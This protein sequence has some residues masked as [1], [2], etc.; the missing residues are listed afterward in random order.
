MQYLLWKEW[1]ERRLWLLLW[2]LA[3]AGTA[4]VGKGPSPFGFDVPAGWT[5]IPALFAL[6]SGLAG[7]GSE[8]VGGRAA[9]L[10]SR[11]V[12]WGRVLLAK[13]LPG[14]ATALLGAIVG[15]VAC[16]FTL[17]AH[18]L[19]FV[20]PLSLTLGALGIGVVML[21][22]YLIGLACSTTLRVLAGAA[23]ALLLW[24]ALMMAGAFSLESQSDVS[25]A[26]SFIGSLAGP[27]LAGLVLARFGLTLAPG[28]RLARFVLLL[29]VP[30]ALGALLDLTP[31][32][33]LL[34]RTWPDV[35]VSPSGRYAIAR[36]QTKNREQAWWVTLDEGARLPLPDVSGNFLCWLPNDRY[37]TAFMDDTQQWRIS[38]YWY[39]GGRIVRRAVES[40]VAARYPERD[41]FQPS[42]DGRHL[43]Y[44]ADT[45]LL[46]LDLTT[47][48]TRTLA[49]LDAA[50][51][52]RFSRHRSPYERFWWQDAATVGYIDPVTEKRAVVTVR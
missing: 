34:N 2:L 20:T 37:V 14:A 8:L 43:L 41:D 11:P 31:A 48:A 26:W 28:V 35:L 18:Y 5:M 25:P 44:G 46:L 42:P 24:L 33:T 45:A 27:P 15:A 4:L 13:V 39:E 23:L 7:Y 12:G 19:P 3:M 16:R 51:R 49:G 22:V 36:E 6:L 29:F 32:N 52:E 30:L 38:L 17:P 1:Q 47:G 10:F 40:P 21:T 50:A 9:F